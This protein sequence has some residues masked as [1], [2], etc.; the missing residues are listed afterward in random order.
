MIF[1]DVPFSICPGNGNTILTQQNSSPSQKPA[2]QVE[3]MHQAGE[4]QETHGEP[5]TSQDREDAKLGLHCSWSF[6]GKYCSMRS[7]N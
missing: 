2:F 3:A 5:E 6:K 1:Y 4:N 7:L